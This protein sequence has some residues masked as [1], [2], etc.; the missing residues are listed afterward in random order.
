MSNFEL[1]DDYLSNRLTEQDRTS[2]EQQIAGDPSLKSEVEFQRRVVEGV[3]SA[4]AAEIKQMLK[5]VPL[6]GNTWSIGK[7]TTAAVTVGI[8]ATSLYF[9]MK[10]DSLTVPVTDEQHNE[11]L[12]TP[13][14]EETVVLPADSE[15]EDSHK[16]AEPVKERIEASGKSKVASPVTKPEIQVVDP[17]EEF[18]ETK[19]AIDHTTPG[20]SEISPSKMEVIT[21]VPDKKHNFH[22]Q[23]V[24][25]KLMLYG[26]FDKTLYEILEIH[27]EGHAVFLFYKENY[28][29][30]DESQ[31]KITALQP[32]HDAQLLKKLKEYRGR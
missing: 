25:S 6:N 26:P 29:L 19:T 31:S 22:Y 2:F 27:G 21:G 23:F 11:K 4:R 1:I 20:R 10:E 16:D 30:L 14:S 13:K 28:Y 12:K 24:Q 18:E 17:S 5:N 15:N 9:Y 32:I 7:I 8:V 3:R